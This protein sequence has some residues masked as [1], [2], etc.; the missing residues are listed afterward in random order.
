MPLNIQTA[1]TCEKMQKT[2]LPG[3]AFEKEK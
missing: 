3:M 2:G 1:Q